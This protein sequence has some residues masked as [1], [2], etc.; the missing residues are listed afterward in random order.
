MEA[1]RYQ[2]GLEEEIIES[3]DR[4]C[5]VFGP[6][7]NLNLNALHP[8]DIYRVISGSRYDFYKYEFMTKLA[9]AIRYTFISLRDNL[10]LANTE[11]VQIFIRALSKIGEESAYGDVWRATTKVSSDLF[12]LKTSK[13]GL[14]NVIVYHEF[15]VGTIFLNKLRSEIP[16]FMFVYGLFKCSAPVHPAIRL[17]NFKDE[18]I[19]NFCKTA[20]TI[21]DVMTDEERALADRSERQAEQLRANGNEKEAERLE[22]RLDYLYDKLEE[23]LEEERSNYLVIEHI[24]GSL[25]MV[26]EIIR[27]NN[28]EN[29]LSYLVQLAAGLELALHRFDFTHYDLH[30]D[31]ILMRPIGRLDVRTFV[32]A[33]FHKS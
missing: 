21:D 19:D 30:T 26:D 24:R 1:Q 31:N 16:T 14:N 27:P 13:T 8:P 33:K 2:L 6:A 5:E 25:P 12:L 17:K 22:V 29:I 9:C 20:K 10:G 28:V 18:R 32:R 23:R 4:T 7:A 3:Y 11:A 15:F